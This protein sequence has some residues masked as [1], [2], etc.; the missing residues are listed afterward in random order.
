MATLKRPRTLLDEFTTEAPHVTEVRR[1]LQTLLREHRSTDRKVFMFTSASRG[2]GKSTTCAL[3]GLVA[4]RIFHRRILVIDTDMRRPTGHTLLAVSRSPGLFEYLVHGASIDVV[5]HP[6]L[7]PSLHLI[8]AGQ[9]SARVSESFSDTKFAELL[10]AVR[11]SYD[12]IFV[13]TAPVIPVIEPIMIAELVDGIV[14]VASAGV[15]PIPLIR[16]MVSILEP[17]RDKI[18]GGILCNASEGLPYFYDYAYYGYK[19]TS[20][21]R[22]RSETSSIDPGTSGEPSNH[23]PAAGG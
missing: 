21:Q 8:P 2:E 5:Q 19:P 9:A 18:V 15:T 20:S 1:M 6:T 4:A 16:R 12:F 17:V 7:V 13:D 10:A 22:R 3:V 14:L 23:D 11:D